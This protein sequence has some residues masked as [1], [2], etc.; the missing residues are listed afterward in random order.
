MIVAV[1]S[2]KGGVG[3]TTTAVTLAAAFAER[4]APSLVIDLD[5]QA[6]ASRALGLRREELVP[7]LYD[8]LFR[9]I[10]PDQ[11]VR[12]TALANLHVLPASVDLLHADLDLFQRARKDELLA[13]ALVPLRLRYDFI[14]LDCPPA[15]G[16]LVHNA[17]L[18]A[19]ALL[20]PCSPHPLA[21]DG[22]DVTLET[23][24]RARSRSGYP[25]LRAFLLLTQVE[26]RTRL[27]RSA[28]ERLAGAAREVP[29]ERLAV[30][31]PWSVRLAEAPASGRPVLV[32][33][34]SGAAAMAYRQAAH[35]LATRLGRLPPPDPEVTLE[36]PRP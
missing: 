15:L 32:T 30:A 17:F 1:A 16:L 18:Y 21:F 29:A 31:I 3:K 4:G 9:G 8:V 27:G 28:A 35:E 34:P 6:S 5:A 19:E 7:G 33:D 22:L 2:R 11:A 20:V 10:S 23:A 26:R 24:R 13:R 25:P 12:S 36:V 14:F